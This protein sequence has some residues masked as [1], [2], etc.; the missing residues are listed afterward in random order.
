MRHLTIFTILAP[1][2]ACGCGGPEKEPT[3]ADDVVSGTPGGVD[4]VEDLQ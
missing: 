4:V 1:M 2:A 3:V